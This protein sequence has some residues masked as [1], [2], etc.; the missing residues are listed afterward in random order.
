[1]KNSVTVLAV[2]LILIFSLG[3]DLS[4][5]NRP[6]TPGPDVITGGSEGD[7]HP[8]GGDGLSDGSGTRNTYTSITTGEKAPTMEAAN[9]FSNPIE[10]FIYR[11]FSRWFVV[12]E[13]N[14]RFEQA[15]GKRSKKSNSVTFDIALPSRKAAQ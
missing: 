12:S 4:A 1:M 15:Q 6:Y 13:R 10:R 8:W 3:G 9:T 11:V 5:R 14:H 7:D 2:A